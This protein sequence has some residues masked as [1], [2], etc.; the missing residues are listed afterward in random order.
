MTPSAEGAESF[1]GAMFDWEFSS[2]DM[3]NG[4]TYNFAKQAGEE[5]PTAGM[6]QITDEME[7]CPPHW[8]SYIMVEKCTAA[9]AK[10]ES[11]GAT[12]IRPRTEVGMG[13]FAVVKDPQ[14]AVFS[15][16]EPKEEG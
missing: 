1:Y 5:N 6:M 14:G 7:G 4:M 8:M 13:I 2:M 11:L 3:G 10:A 9:I 15:V 12:I 16:W